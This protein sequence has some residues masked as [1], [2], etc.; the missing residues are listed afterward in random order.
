MASSGLLAAA[1]AATTATSN[2][3]SVV[4]NAAT[5]AMAGGDKSAVFVAAP[6]NGWLFWNTDGNPHTP[7]EGVRL[8]DLNSTSSFHVGDLL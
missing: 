3:F 8:L 6:N 4:L 1:F 2:R 7:E 5:V